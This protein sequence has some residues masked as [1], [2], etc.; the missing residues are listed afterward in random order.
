MTFRFSVRAF[1]AAFAFLFSLSLAGGAHAA[2]DKLWNKISSVASAIGVPHDA[3]ELTRF[4]VYY[5]EDAAIVFA[6]AAAE[7]YPFF[8][9]VG[10]AKVMKG[11]N[12]PGVGVFDK[13]TCK[14]PI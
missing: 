7:D 5:P 12:V 11:R 1:F 9:L 10:A 3:I 6:R 8:G 14:S 4:S 13:N 2:N